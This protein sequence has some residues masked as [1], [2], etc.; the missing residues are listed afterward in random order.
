MTQLDIDIGNVLS[1]TTD[2]RYKVVLPKMYFSHFITKR[3]D[4]EFYTRELKFTRDWNWLI[5]ACKYLRDWMVARIDPNSY[6]YTWD[7]KGIDPSQYVK[8]RTKLF[9]ILMFKLEN[10]LFTMDFIQVL[11]VVKEIIKKVF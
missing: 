8:G 9:G 7:L 1:T 10:S 3:P 11:R 5:P 6:V 2:Y 4:L